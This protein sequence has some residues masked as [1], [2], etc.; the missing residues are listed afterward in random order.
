M[1]LFLTPL[2]DTP[3]ALTGPPFLR[4]AE[5]LARVRRH[6]SVSENLTTYTLS[7]GT[8]AGTQGPM[9]NQHG[10]GGITPVLV[11]RD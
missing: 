4:P 2:P 8:L 5:R 10:P 9:S 6:L 1:N 7:S 11:L 3:W